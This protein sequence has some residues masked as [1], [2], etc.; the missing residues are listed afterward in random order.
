MVATPPRVTDPA[1]DSG[2]AAVAIWVKTPGRSPVKTRLAAT[3][4]TAQAETFYGHAVA[5]VAA[6]VRAAVVHLGADALTP[7]WAV[8]EPEP[9]AA[10]S[11]GGFDTVGQGTGGLGERLAH[12]Y[13]ALRERH[14]RVFF[15]G[16]D[17]PQLAPM[18]IVEA[19][20]CL[21]RNRVDG[22][23]HGRADFVVGPADDGGFYL[24]GGR[25]AL[26]RTVWTE[27]PYS[28]AGTL[29][30]LAPRLQAHGTLTMLP[31]AF[32]VDTAAELAQLGG[33]LAAARDVLLPE[34]RTL[35]AWL[36]AGGLT[37]A[38]HAR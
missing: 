1:P 9:D 15:I 2:S 36:V 18:V 34:Q 33:V 17:A 32:D 37:D 21:T 27:V 10:A 3:I 35:L 13:D 22:G 26:P 14:A 29:A 25:L 16:A 38:E 8:A 7:Y 20:R 6:V 31:P 4:G 19:V 24:F 11:W 5:A 30:A 23:G 12:V 28:D